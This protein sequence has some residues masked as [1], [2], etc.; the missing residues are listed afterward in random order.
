MTAAASERLGGRLAIVDGDT[1]LTYAGLVEAAQTFAAALVASG[2]A[3]GDRVAIWLFNGIEWVV[4]VLGIFEAGAVL[5]P[6][7]SGTPLRTLR[8]ISVDVGV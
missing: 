1:R 2:V 7:A 4:A 5:V 3:P 8:L 6:I